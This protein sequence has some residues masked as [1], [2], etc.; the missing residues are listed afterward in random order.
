MLSARPR[1]TRCW[2]IGR[3]ARCGLRMI[4]RFK[5]QRM[6]LISV[7]QCNR[8]DL[9]VT[10]AYPRLVQTRAKNRQAARFE[11]E[12]SRSPNLGRRHQ[13]SGPPRDSL[14][15]NDS[16]SSSGN[17]GPQVPRSRRL[18]SS[19]LEIFL[20]ERA[21]SLQPSFHRLTSPLNTPLTFHWCDPTPDR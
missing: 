4:N 8:T 2:S 18:D 16:R 14:P 19:F 5:S 20:E 13:K 15:S 7:S 1:F 9:V 6:P 3:A 11:R 21:P 17:H 10:P 12:M